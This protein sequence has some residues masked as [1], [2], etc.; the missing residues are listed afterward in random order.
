MLQAEINL[1]FI[2]ADA[3]GPKHLQVMLSRAK[4]DQ[5]TAD[6]VERTLGPVRDA[7]KDAQLKPADINQ[8]I[9]VGGQTRM[10]AVQ[11]AVKKF[12]GR[13]P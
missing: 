10:P 2:S 13:E 6:L 1:P 8:V 5:L 7:L 9:L 4:L 12:F 11:D 3:S